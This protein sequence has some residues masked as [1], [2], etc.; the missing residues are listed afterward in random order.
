MKMAGNLWSRV[1][2]WNGPRKRSIVLELGIASAVLVLL[3]FFVGT[4]L[5]SSSGSVY[6]TA[7]MGSFSPA[8]VKV[9]DAATSSLSADTSSMNP[10]APSEDEGSLSTKYNWTVS[11]VQFKGTQAGS[12]RTAPTGTYTAI[13]SPAQPSNS[14]SATLTFTPNVPGYWQVSTT[15]GVTI[16]DSKTNKTWT[17]S[18]NAGPEDVTSYV[19]HIE[20][21]ETVVDD[22]TEQISV[23]EQVALTAEFGPSDQTITWNPAGNVIKGYTQSL[24]TASVT[25]LTGADLHATTINFYYVSAGASGTEQGDAD[26]VVLSLSLNGS[27]P[28]YTTFDEYEPNVTFTATYE[29]TMAADNNYIGDYNQVTDAWSSDI[30]LHFGGSFYPPRDASGIYTPGIEFSASWSQPPTQ[31]GDNFF[32]VQ[33]ISS[34]DIYYYDSQG[35]EHSLEWPVGS[36][37]LLDTS[38]PY[39]YEIGGPPGTSGSTSD[40]PALNLTSAATLA[41]DSMTASMHLMYQPSTP[42]SIPI[43]IE[44][45]DW[46]EDGLVTNT[47]G[48]WSATGSPSPGGQISG[49][50]EIVEPTLVNNVKDIS[51]Q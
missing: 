43:P 25:N 16:T 20:Y 9:G 26:D 7:N 40:S 50:Q 28:V 6:V 21:D 38:L 37:Y 24:T 5:G 42:N 3:A 8:I 11:Q 45:V 32:F 15:C 17:G 1:W 34:L 39:G 22:K 23:G 46:G 18:G 51:W 19:L 36:G 44:R 4:R 49:T 35:N 14:S 47:N 31:Y 33:T 48:S 41:G 12:F 13:I 27:S 10:P 29:G 30:W 2:N